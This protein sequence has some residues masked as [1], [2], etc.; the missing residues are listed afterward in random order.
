MSPIIVAIL[1]SLF[2]LFLGIVFVAYA[3]EFNRRNI[4]LHKEKDLL[5]ASF[6]EALLKSKLEIQEETFKKVSLDLHDNVGQMLSL[7][8]LNLNTLPPGNS[9][10]LDEKLENA[11]DMLTK[12]IQEVRDIA[13]TMNSEVINRIGIAHAIEI[14][15]QNIKKLSTLQVS[16]TWTDEMLNIDPQVEL[17]LF[18]IVQESLHNVIKHSQAN[19]LEV[20]GTYVD[21]YF[22]LIV[23]DNGVGFDP[24]ETFNN[25][26]GLLN[27][28]SRC[29]LINANLQINSSV[30]KGTI[31]TISL[32]IV[33]AENTIHSIPK[34]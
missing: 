30:G 19:K 18:R 16:F 27:L 6:Q 20:I 4:K 8:K 14:E 23:S 5:N 29:K 9:K 11:K 26:S 7:V 17:I 21:N 28:E 10:E 32:P 22:Q 2:A 1:G 34:D 13:R 33:P 3:L 31:I 25:G 12:I 15:I 24:S